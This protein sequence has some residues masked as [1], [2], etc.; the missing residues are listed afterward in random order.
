MQN[1]FA[2]PSAQRRVGIPL[3]CPLSCC[4]LSHGP[5]FLLYEDPGAMVQHPRRKAVPPFSTTGR[6]KVAFLRFFDDP[7]RHRKIDVFSNHQKTSKIVK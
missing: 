5:F 4:L 3:D 2:G 1:K 7:G 6:S